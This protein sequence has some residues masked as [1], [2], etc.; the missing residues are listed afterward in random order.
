[1]QKLEKRTPDVFIIIPFYLHCFEFTDKKKSIQKHEL[2]SLNFLKNDILQ[3]TNSEY[4]LDKKEK[5]KRAT[6]EIK[7]L[8]K[9]IPPRIK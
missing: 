2:P 3:I 6:L 5:K 1:M 7:I 9:N 8:F 4:E